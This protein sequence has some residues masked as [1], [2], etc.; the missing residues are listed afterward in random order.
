VGLITETFQDPSSD[1]LPTILASARETGAELAVLPELP[2][3]RWFP[4]SR[5]PSDDDA[6]PFGGPRQ[7][8]LATAARAAGVAVLGGAV[9]QDRVTGQ[10]HNTAL[11]IGPGGSVVA[12]YRKLIVPNEPG[13]WEAC[14]YNPGTLP[15]MPFT[16]LTMPLGIQICSDVNRPSGAELLAAA[17]AELL[18]VPRAT[19]EASYPRWRLVMRSLAVTSAAY[20]VSVNRPRPEGTAPIGGPS[21]VIA[22]DGTVLLETTDALAT[23][24]LER[25]EVARWREE[26]P[27]YLS[28]PAGVYAVGW[29]RQATT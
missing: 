10:R 24:R 18:L 15:P 17:G 14:H 23:V 7:Q 3:D 25:A 8:R 26:Y 4:E 20:V 5:T 9:Q 11:L 22:P 19:P 6:E 1:A 12:S 13:F 29:Q 2:L 27:G 21:L 28:R 16:G